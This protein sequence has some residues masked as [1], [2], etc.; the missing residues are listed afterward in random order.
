MNESKPSGAPAATVAG[1]TKRFG[2]LTAVHDV[3][4]EVRTGSVHALLGENGAGKTTLVRLLSGEL[5][6]DEGTISV[7]GEC[8]SFRSPRDARR[9]G[10]RLVHQHPT[11]I[12]NLTIEENFLLAFKSVSATTSRRDFSERLRGEAAVLGIKIDPSRPVSDLSV[13]QRQWVEVFG[14]I[15]AGGRLIILDEPTAHLSPLEG[16]RLLDE[17]ARLASGGLTVMLITHKLREVRQFSEVVTVMRRGRVVATESVA[18]LS[19]ATLASMMVD[20]YRDLRV[21]ENESGRSRG[22]VLLVLS[23]VSCAGHYRHS[24]LSNVSFDIHR[25]EVVG[26]AGVSGNGQTELARVVAGI[27]APTSGTVMRH[28]GA[29]VCV[30]YIPDDRINVATASSLSVRDNLSMRDFDRPPYAHYGLLAQ[31]ALREHAEAMADQFGV[32]RT[33]LD[34]PVRVLSG[35]NIQRVVVARELTANPDLVVAHNPT[36]GLDLETALFVRNQ[37]RD[38]A[39]RG[40]ALLLISDDIDELQWLADRVLVLHGSRI[41]GDVPRALFDSALVARLMAGGSADGLGRKS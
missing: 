35:G 36:A 5:L 18:D 25:G 34:A 28:G 11:L 6:P 39:S 19:D 15:F 27:A 22:D 16:D 13:A 8:Q 33:S 40:G 26:V 31:P 1:V 24:A 2:E 41:V 21:P 20:G 7:F 32:R 23:D 9:I 14:A 37:L 10:I 38:V 17:L 30:R 4:F 3:S 29:E 12:P